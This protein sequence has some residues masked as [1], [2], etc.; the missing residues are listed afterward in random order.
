M[1]TALLLLMGAGLVTSIIITC[2]SLKRNAE[3]DRLLCEYEANK[4][5]YGYEIRQLIYENQSLKS[6]NFKLR[7]HRPGPIEIPKGTIDAV[8][9]AMKVSHPDN[10]GN[11]NDFI[12]YREVYMKLTKKNS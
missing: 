2:F 8:K 10:G 12:K 9:L 5:Q 4:R 7:S 3:Q 1:N 6:E 11:Q